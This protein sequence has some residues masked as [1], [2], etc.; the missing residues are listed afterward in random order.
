[1]NMCTCNHGVN[2]YEMQT[3]IRYSF[4]HSGKHT[5]VDQVSLIQPCTH[6]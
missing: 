1:M 2:T 4:I 3:Y 6:I 5:K